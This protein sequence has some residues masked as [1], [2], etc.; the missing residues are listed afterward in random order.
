MYPDRHDRL[1]RNH[2]REALSEALAEEVLMR[3][4]KILG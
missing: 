2:A 4:T 1:T 3:L